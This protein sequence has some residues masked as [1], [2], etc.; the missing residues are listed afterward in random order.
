MLPADGSRGSRSGWV[1]LVPLL[2]FAAGASAEV[3]VLCE[4]GSGDVLIAE[5]IDESRQR[6]MDG[7]FPGSRTA[8]VWIEE[9]CPARRCGA[10]GS[11]LTGEPPPPRS[12]RSEDWMVVCDPSSGAVGVVESPPP[13][14]F[15]PLRGADGTASGRLDRARA[16]AWAT[17]SCPS[18]ECTPEGGCAS[19]AAD[20]ASPSA[21][22]WVAG[23]VSSVTLSRAGASPGAVAGPTAGPAG[24]SGPPSA[25]LSPLVSNTKA[26][27]EGCNYPAALASID[28]MA[29]FDPQ[30]PFLVAN[31]EKLR[32]LAR[33]QEKTE[34]TIW[35]ASSAL[36]AGDLKRSRAIAQ[37]AA[38]TAVSCQNQAV[39]TLLNGIDTAIRQT[40][41]LKSL[42]RRRVA[43]SLLPG[44]VSLSHAL[45]GAQS[46]A[47]I[48]VDALIAETAAAFGADLPLNALDPCTF[49]YQYPDTSSL[50]PTCACPGYRF[51]PGQFRCVN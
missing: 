34:E 24:S 7:P 9:S 42:E 20:A 30:H 1:A 35:Q 31:R 2:L 28:Q 40:R 45:S 47:P 5:E 41:E 51:D 38:D 18:G 33:R 27:A 17:A 44:L 48:D 10:S 43:A 3:W 14:G 49:K 16:R 22:G 36:Q 19:A 11:C 23:E 37:T 50:E 21:G 25:N 6:V 4:V 29:N 13:A 15:V 32:S 46:G 12:S 26:A 39:A 8:T